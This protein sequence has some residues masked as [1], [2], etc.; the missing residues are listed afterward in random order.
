MKSAIQ[1]GTETII[2]LIIAIILLLILIVLT[3]TGVI[4]PGKSL[5]GILGSLGINLT[6]LWPW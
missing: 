4:N 3:I 6:K 2:V 5:A 1:L